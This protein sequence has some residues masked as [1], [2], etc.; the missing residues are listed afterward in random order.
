MVSND[1]KVFAKKNRRGGLPSSG[2]ILDL[3]RGRHEIKNDGLKRCCSPGLH[4]G[5]MAAGM[6]TKQN[7]LTESFAHSMDICHTQP[8][9]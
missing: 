4:L 2:G 9:R 1:A 5:G 3:V 6:A 8:C 7:T